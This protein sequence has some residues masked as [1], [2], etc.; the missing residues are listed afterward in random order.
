[1]KRTKVDLLNKAVSELKKDYLPTISVLLQERLSSLQALYL[2]GFQKKKQSAISLNKE[3]SKVTFAYDYDILVIA[4]A[5]SS[6]QLER[7][8]ADIQK[9]LGISV[10][11]ITATSKQTQ[12]D[13]DNNSPFFHQ[14][15]QLNDALFTAD[16]KPF[17]WK[18][19]A[20]N[21]VQTEEEK[22]IAFVRWRDRKNTAE[23]F[24]TGGTEVEHSEQV[25]VKV[26]LYSQA[27][28]QACLGLLTY[29]YGYTPSNYNLK[30]LYR[31]CSSFWSFPR[32]IF[33]LNT[34]EE[35][36]VFKEFSEVANDMRENAYSSIGW[37]NAYRYDE[38]CDRFLAECTKLVSG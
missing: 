38:R 8:Q 37:D 18:F 33:P 5:A 36:D 7:L 21:G 10:F 16:N 31:L 29:F 32:D 24:Y 34:E 35:K 14:V 9:S 30:Y 11:L 25:A 23:G 15:L 12:E 17:K 22:K 6:K 19:H 26:L 13:L 3:E 20:N 4:D 2:F 28:E 27:I 1:M